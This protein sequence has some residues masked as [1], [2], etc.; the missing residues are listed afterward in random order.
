MNQSQSKAKDEFYGDKN[1]LAR[2]ECYNDIQKF[3]GNK[4]GSLKNDMFALLCLQDAVN[5]L[6]SDLQPACSQ[7]VWE[8][9]VNNNNF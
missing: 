3:C 5:R 9:K 8:Y 4:L 6:N 1:I 2:V 7:I